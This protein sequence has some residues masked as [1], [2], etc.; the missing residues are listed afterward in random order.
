MAEPWENFGYPVIELPPSACGS[1]DAVVRFLVGELT[2]TGRIRS[3]NAPRII[4]QILH[5]EKL[6][7]TNLGRGIAIPHSKSDAVDDVLGM[8]G[9]SSEG[10]AWPGNTDTI[11][12]RVVCLLVT[13]TSKPGEAL[14]ALEALSQQLRG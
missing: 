6:G 4:R 12:V 9:E 7:S 11:P 14:R 10:V 1:S 8:I 5:R 3:E 2:R 13:P